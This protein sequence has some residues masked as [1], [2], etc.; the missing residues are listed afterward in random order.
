MISYSVWLLCTFVVVSSLSFYFLSLLYLIPAF[1]LLTYMYQR[2]LSPWACCPS[3]FCS[4]PFS[5]SL[6]LP[7]LSDFLVISL[8]PFLFQFLSLSTPTPLSFS[9]LSSSCL[10]ILSILPYNQ[11]LSPVAIAMSRSIV[12]QSKFRHVFGQAAKAEQSYDDIRVSK[13]TWDSSFSAVNPKFLAVIVES[14]GGGAILVLP[15]CK[16]RRCTCSFSLQGAIL[17]SHFHV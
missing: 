10:F 2:F 3:L 11:P 17:N 13:V 16:V 7:L 9:P 4:F 8:I 14:S 1:L 12:R 6:C 15:L 5:F